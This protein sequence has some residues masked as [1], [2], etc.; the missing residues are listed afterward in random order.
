MFLKLL[1]N[2][3]L[4]Q[5]LHSTSSTTFTLL[6]NFFAVAFAFG[7]ASSCI[8]S[9]GDGFVSS[10]L[11]CSVGCSSLVVSVTSLTIGAVASSVLFSLT[12]SLLIIKMV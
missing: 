6:G 9:A 2:I 11:I 3:F 12:S 7:L 4:V 8:C 5:A 1:G 10:S